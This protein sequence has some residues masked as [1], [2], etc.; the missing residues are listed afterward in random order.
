MKRT[1]TH[2][3]S[4]ACLAG[5]LLAC[6]PPA[7]EFRSALPK[8]ENVTVNIPEQNQTAS[9]LSSS[10]SALVGQKSDFY[11]QTYYTA[12]GINLVGRAVVKLVEGIASFPPTEIKG[13][14][15][16]WGPHSDNND[17]NEWMMT[18]ERIKEGQQY[19]WRIEGKHK[20]DNEFLTL[21]SGTFEPEGKDLGR[22]W[23]ELDFNMIGQLDPTED[24]KGLVAYAFE[25]TE[26][27]LNVRV[28][29]N[30]VDLNGAP[31]EAGYAFG[32]TTQGEGFI[33]FAAPADIHEKG[34]LGSADENVLIRTRWTQSGAGR[35]DVVATDGDLDASVAQASQCWDE[36]FVSQYEVL[37]IDQEIFEEN[38]E[39]KAC[40]LEEA[41]LP[42][43]GELPKETDV[44]N[45]HVE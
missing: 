40:V 34:K 17:P 6:V 24:T 31:V 45:P 44:Q 3:F 37:K 16:V 38:G 18:V 23:F 5:S 29:F 33:I 12:R 2:L 43:D 30:G 35:A 22:G 28:R 39:E 8:Q 32:E 20:A 14:T 25:K 10:R 42:T 7:D 36:R 19:H 26:A 1:W 41:Q 9:G 13:D 15:A 4:T 27:K 21:A 11:S